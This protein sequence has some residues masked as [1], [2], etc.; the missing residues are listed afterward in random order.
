MLSFTN[1]ILSFVLRSDC[2][3]GKGALI[4]STDYLIANKNSIAKEK[5]RALEIDLVKSH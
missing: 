4:I 2:G 1:L 5:S 3:E